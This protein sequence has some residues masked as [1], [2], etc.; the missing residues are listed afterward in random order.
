MKAYFVESPVGIFILD[1]KANVVD[2]LLFSPDPRD[3]ALELRQIQEGKI[4]PQLL[5]LLKRAADKH[6][7]MVFENEQLARTTEREGKLNV[8]VEATPVGE[9]FR[10][11][12]SSEEQENREKWLREQSLESPVLKSARAYNEFSRRVTLQLARVEVARAAAKRDLSAVQAVRAMDD[13][14]KTLNLLAGRVREW[15]G[16]HFPEMDRLVE[17]H[18]TYARLVAKLGNRR[19]FTPEALEREG[20][21]SEKTGELA[22]AASKSMGADMDDSDLAV[23]QSFCELMLSLYKFREKSVGYVEDSLK[24]IAPNMTEIVGASLSARLISIAG[25]LDNLAK[26][27][28]STL[29]VLG[30]EKALF[31]SLKTGARPPKHGVI[32]QHTAI[33]QSPRWQRGKIARALSGKLSIA[34]RVDAFG[35]DFIGEKLRDSVNKKIDEIKERYKTPPPPTKKKEIARRR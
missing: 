23:L 27:P 22:K 2:K 35:G 21:P 24:Q 13:L 31:R 3:A 25:S 11:R 14:D 5:E 9:Q 33:H 10:T 6:S 32:F 4:S 17:R 28:A 29:Q 20:M 26:M 15:Y 16:L 19:N 7:P 30:A 34:A 12:L 18:D 8:S 1:E